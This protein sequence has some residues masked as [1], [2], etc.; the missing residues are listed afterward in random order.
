MSVSRELE[1]KVNEYLSY[2]KEHIAGV[3]VAYYK[4]CVPLLERRNL[5]TIFSDEELYQAV[6]ELRSIIRN[7]DESKYSSTEFEGYRMHYYPTCSEL[8]SIDFNWK[9]RYAFDLAWDHHWRHNPH[10]IN[11]WY[12][13]Q[14]KM[15]LKFM[16]EMICDWVSVG[17]LKGTSTIA[18]YYK[19][20]SKE[21]RMLGDQC[22]DVESLMSHV[23]CIEK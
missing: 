5:S 11:Y 13:R 16:L 9:Q 1:Q 10:H 22:F 2:L 17:N 23:L 7:H 3:Q 19:Y 6:L 21:K 4:F 14:E 12:E 18:W 20:A 15:P 8:E